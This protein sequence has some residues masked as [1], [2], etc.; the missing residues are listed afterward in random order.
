MTDVITLIM[1]DDLGWVTVISGFAISNIMWFEKYVHENDENLKYM[2][3]K[4]KTV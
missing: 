1:I 3:R 2:F 4:K